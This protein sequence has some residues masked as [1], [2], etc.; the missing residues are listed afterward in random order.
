MA[1]KLETVLSRGIFNTRPRD[2]YDIFILATTQKY[3]KALLKKALLATAEHRGSTERIAD[4]NTIINTIAES[5]D[6]LDIWKKY[7]KKFTYAKD[8]SYED[9]IG[10]IR[11]LL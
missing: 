3:D 5:N 2:F 4:S 10:A 7:Q 1:E 6:L 8:I 9:I 11:D